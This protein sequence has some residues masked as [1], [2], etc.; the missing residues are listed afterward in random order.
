M[1]KRTFDLR[2]GWRLAGFDGYGETVAARA[3]PQALPNLLWIDAAVPGSV[4]LDLMRAG[5]IADVYRDC[6]SLAAQW[7]EQ[8]YWFYQT[9]FDAPADASRCHLVFDSLDLDALV[10]LNGELIGEH[11][12]AFRPLRI[13]VSG[14]LRAS[15]NELIVRVDAGLL[16]SADRRVGDYHDEITAVAT[17]RPVLRKPHYACRWDWSPRLMNVG[18]AGGVRLESFCEVHLQEVT[19]IADADGIVRVR[20]HVE[21]ATSDAIPITLQINARPAGDAFGEACTLIG[22]PDATAQ[23]A[24]GVHSIEHVVKVANPHRWWPRGFGDQP[25]YDVRVD[26]LRSEEVVDTATRRVGFRTVA[27]RQPPADDGGSLFH[28]EV[29]GHP[30]FCKGA[31]WVPADL[32]WPRVTPDDCEALV[33]LAVEMNSNLLRVW[34]GGLYESDAFYEACDRH[35]VLVWQDLAFAC[36]TYP[37][38]DSAFVRELEAEVRG[39]VRRIAHHPSLVLW[40]GNNE[41]EVGVADGWIKCTDDVWAATQEFFNETLRG[42]VDEEDASRP[43]WPSSPSSPDESAPN[44]QHAGDQHP[45]FVGLGN[46]KGDFWQYRDDA[47]RFPNEGGI[48][49]PSTPKTLREILPESEREIGS[50]TWMHHDNTQN[51]W[52][53]EPMIDHLLRT[54]FIADPR[55]LAF[56]DYVR[57]AA[58]LHGEALE[59]AI[60]N[61]RRRKFASSAAVFW[62]FNDTWPAVTSWTPIDYYRRRKPAFWYVKRAFAPLRAVCVVEGSDVLVCAVND[63]LEARRLTLR[64]GLFGIAGER[65]VDESLACTCPPNGAHVAARIPLSA[66]DAVGTTTHGAFAILTDG[67]THVSTQRLFRER[68]RDLAWQRAMVSCERDGDSLIFASDTFAWSVCFDTDGETASADNH[69]DLL[70]GIPYRLPWRNDCPAPR[71]VQSAN[72]IA[73]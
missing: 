8:H 19:V 65:P 45:W 34:G 10:F 35:G 48:L 32:L 33:A 72:P 23:V 29:N 6:N 12:N 54:N 13:D 39:N 57:Y 36:S 70:P 15:G 28:I 41:I 60:D 44:A 69:F 68:F 66:W 61:W 71:D 63:T 46:A 5:W 42:W 67:D 51:T 40:C 25:L 2:E 43:Y 24:P 59:T 56:E 62:M 17:S 20:A 18:V 22:A 14:K 4:Y 3:L 16:A 26:L 37:I 27:L 55:G 11:H 64:Y 31:N 1:R 47:S 50:R 73:K 53:G 30:I 7:V 58:I 52:R 49:G 21:N 9:H 38:D